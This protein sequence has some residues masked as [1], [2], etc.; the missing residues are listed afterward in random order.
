MVSSS[1]NSVLRNPLLYGPYA[2][3]TCTN[4]PRVLPSGGVKPAGKTKTITAG[5][6][7]HQPTGRCFIAETGTNAGK[8]VMRTPMFGTIKT[9]PVDRKDRESTEG[10]NAVMLF[11]VY[12][13]QNTTLSLNNWIQTMS[14]KE[15]YSTISISGSATRRTRLGTTRT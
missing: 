13:L 5:K 9:L 1:S 10:Q 14:L 11:D 8:L 12:N 7:I 15:L 3:G 4:G 2:T 6:T